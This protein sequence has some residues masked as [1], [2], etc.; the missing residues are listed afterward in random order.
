[1]SAHRID[2]IPAQPWALAKARYT[3]DLSDEEQSLFE[4]AT[5]DNIFYRASAAE[6]K[7]KAES[8]TRAVHEKM[9]P[10]LEA[11]E[12]Y[13]KAMDVYANTYSLALAPIWGSIRVLLQYASDFGKYYEKIVDILARIGDVLPRFRIY[14]RLFPDHTRLVLA[15]ADAY[16][17][18]I[19]F[20]TDAKAV[21][22]AGKNS[23]KPFKIIWKPFSKRFDA[24]LYQF[25]R[26]QKEVEKEA[27][28]SHMI[29]SK[30][31]REMEQANRELQERNMKKEM[32]RQVLTRLSTGEYQANHNRARCV[33]IDGT[34][35]WVL[36]HPSFTAWLQDSKSGCF[37][38][39]GIPGSGKTVLASAIID[40]LLVRDTDNEAVVAYYY[41]D[42]AN[43]TTLEMGT[44]IGSLVRQLIE[45]LEP[46]ITDQL[47]EEVN[48]CYE[49]VSPNLICGGLTKLLHRFIDQSKSVF[50]VLDG[51]DELSR[52]NQS[53]LHRIVSETIDH[54]NCAVKVFLTSRREER[55]IRKLFAEYSSIDMSDTQNQTQISQYIRCTIEGRIKSEELRI[56][57]PDLKD[58]II[59]AL[60][61]G[62]KD[63]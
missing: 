24:Y 1:M 33:R 49:T 31:E 63:M 25:R 51:I 53:E 5:L 17:D 32:R 40:S 50:F 27:G 19:K 13:G 61:N 42:Y 55:L 12:D 9:R 26:H 16:L 48:K 15:L 38:C 3:E 43:P 6:K 44:I 52:R 54:N 45:K 20:C 7:H 57:D 2:A 46:E 28:V 47:E 37:C 39:F 4:T 29:E 10:L 30:Q 14:E 8:K 58:E 60:V 18:I 36:S 11:V 41:C 56:R 34:G 21:F 22:T 62:A 23:R 35:E 59:I